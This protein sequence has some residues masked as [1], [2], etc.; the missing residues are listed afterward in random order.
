MFE[1]EIQKV[2][3]DLIPF[4]STF[5]FY[6]LLAGTQGHNPEEC[7]EAG[8]HWDLCMIVKFLGPPF[9]SISMIVALPRYLYDWGT[10]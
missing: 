6:N 3:V 1:T 2:M 7:A 9:L 10:S 8:S 4:H 5:P